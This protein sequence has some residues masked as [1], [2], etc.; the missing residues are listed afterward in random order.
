MLYIF[1][2]RNIFINLLLRLFYVIKNHNTRWQKRLKNINTCFFL[3]CTFFIVKININIF[4]H[5][6]NR[7]KKS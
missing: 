2:C 3:S 5:K 4:L 1:N 6:N 7:N